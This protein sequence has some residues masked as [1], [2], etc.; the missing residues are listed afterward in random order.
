MM[1]R[2]S[3]KLAFIIM[4]AAAIVSVPAVYSQS[5]NASTSPQQVSV[6]DIKEQ[7]ATA[8]S[9]LRSYEYSMVADTGIIYSNQ[10]GPEEVS[11]ITNSTGIVNLDASVAKLTMSSSIKRAGESAVQMYESYLI[12]DT[13]YVR[14][15]DI[16]AKR[17]IP[18][19]TKA[20]FARNEVLGQSNLINHSDLQLAG[21][22]MIGSE[23][24]YVLKGTPDKTISSTFLVL[25]AQSAYAISPVPLPK[26][27]TDVSV[28]DM[29]NNTAFLNSGNVSLTTW[30]AKSSHLIK[31][32]LIEINLEIT[33]ESLNMGSLES[34]KIDAR[35]NETT[36]FEGFNQPVDVALPF[37]ARNAPSLPPTV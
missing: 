31:R 3:S 35:T 12:N 13:E 17:S 23:D 32:V 14:L 2:M 19:M 4:L 33:P 37:E 5:D 30:I 10:T 8:A 24:C 25:Q 28:A 21:D 27:L 29:L 18:D 36:N 26:E 7:M 16:W 34:F 20:L 1:I 11:M 15:N 6:D 9:N 22:E